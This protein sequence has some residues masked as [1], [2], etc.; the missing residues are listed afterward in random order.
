MKD[1]NYKGIM[2]DRIGIIQKAII[3]YYNYNKAA[4]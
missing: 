3:K 4:M 1:F 2:K